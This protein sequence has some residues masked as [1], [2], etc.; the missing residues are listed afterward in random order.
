[1]SYPSPFHKIIAH[2]KGLFEG[3]NFLVSTDTINWIHS[4]ILTITEHGQLYSSDEN[5]NHYL[6]LQSLQSCYVQ[7]FPTLV[8]NTAA[9]TNS[10][11]NI[12]NSNS[13]R[14]KLPTTRR[15]VSGSSD[16]SSN[17]SSN[18]S[19]DP[20]V[21][22]IRTYEN[23][24]LY[25]KI[26]SKSNFGNL[27]SCLI[28]WQ[29]LKPQGLVKKW[30][31]ENK[32]D[33]STTNSKNPHE[34]LVCRFKIYAPIPAKSKNLNFVY[35]LKAPIYQPLNMNE[36]N[37]NNDDSLNNGINESWFYVMGVLKSNGLLN[38]IT[39]NDGT[40]I[41]S[42]DIKSILSSEIRQM[43]HSIFDNSNVLFIGQLKELRNHNN[44]ISS[45]TPFL[46]RDGKL[47]ANNSRILIEFPLHI[48]LEDWFVG[49]NYFSK[50]EYIGCYSPKSKLITPSRELPPPLANYSR[51][52]FRVSKKI[53]IDII[54]AK[55]DSLP[56]NSKSSKIYAE[57][58]MW[59]LP[60][61]RTAIV[62]HS[63]NPFWKEEF[64]TD[65]PIST[66]MIH[67]V[68]KR[69]SFNDST[70]SAGDKVIG[71]VYVTPDILTKQSSNGSTTIMSASTNGANT[72]SASGPGHT[73]NNSISTNSNTINNNINN[74]ITS[75][76]TTS[77]S[78]NNN[79]I[80]RLT[81]YDTTNVPIGKLLISVKL[82]EHHILP[83]QHFRSFE[84]M[85]VHS[86]MKDLITF[87]NNNITPGAFDETAIMLLDIFQSLGVE[88]RWFKS[89][90]EYELTGVDVIT[91]KNFAKRN[92]EAITPSPS[93]VPSTVNAANTTSA[94]GNSS[95]SNNVFNTLFRGSSVFSKSLEKYNL[96]IGQEYLEKVFG[97][98]ILKI[99][100]EKRNC[101]VDPRYVRLQEKALRKGKSI[102]VLDN[103]DNNDS[104]DSL[105][106]DSEDE[107]DREQHEAVVKKMIEI[108]YENLLG[109]A[110][111][112]WKQIYTTSND[113]PDQIK[114]QLKN[115]RI[116][117]EL[118]C[119]PDD[120]VT[121][122]NCLSAF[123]FLRFFCPAILNPKLFY[124][125]KNHQSGLSQRTLTL[126]AKILLNL[127]NRQEFS[128]HKEPH[129][130]RMNEF[131]AKHQPEIYDYFD[132][133]TGRK[134]DFNEKV[135][136][137]SHDVNRFDLGIK[138]DTNSAE[139]P[140]TPYL[141]DKYLR[142]TQLITL[143]DYNRLKPSNPG[144]STPNGSPR[145][146]I[147]NNTSSNNIAGSSSGPDTISIS[148][149]PRESSSA[150][151]IESLTINE[152]K[153]VYQI[154]SLEF[155]KSEFLDLAGDNETEGFI[156]S[157]CRSNENIFSFINSNIGLKDLQKHCTKLMGKIDSLQVFLE[158]FEFPTN[159]LPNELLD[160]DDVDI[161]GKT[162]GILLL[163]EEE[164]DGQTLSN[165]M[166]AIDMLWDSFTYYI[167]S[168]CY[169]DMSTNSLAYVDRDSHVPNNYKKLI[170]QNPLSTL[171]LRF[172]DTK[173]SNH[174][175]NGNGH[176]GLGGYNESYTSSSSSLNGASVLTTGGPT[177]R[178]ASM[179]QSLSNSSISNVLKAPTK[180]P[181][182]KWLS[183]S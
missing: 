41:Y 172:S 120:K 169:L 10:T 87:I 99:V 2:K 32:V 180:N 125:T 40:L 53:T 29:S 168:K 56:T 14:L 150:N 9:L 130:G 181:F 171:K 85:L 75:T 155:E 156:K 1:M 86:P 92:S 82:K 77:I 116:K 58:R 44:Q 31:C 26:A 98:F 102:D 7:I 25:L 16:S 21:I 70:Y 178:S 166:Q 176:K 78:N 42:I 141:I 118:V 137:L 157:L 167:L 18:E 6:L 43:H 161:S 152:E 147:T 158:N 179:S 128:P 107:E 136:D 111:E 19:S 36:T 34:L 45:S 146:N 49:L 13:R 67:I 27:I 63:A 51:E 46:V 162:R 79:E 183:K 37:N 3:R 30:Y 100:D 90:M 69:C 173:S 33:I 11:S 165:G 160:E 163:D 22:F 97:K 35:G 149:I 126:L 113:L 101:E 119:D 83:P 84:N 94:A 48:D 5:D 109:Y 52:H 159:Y 15:S 127:A 104:D 154:G 122:L 62:N 144:G 23:D 114:T 59:G 170:D 135:L 38:F 12:T 17:N 61:S 121:S 145:A 64:S 20:P 93:I 4:H 88:E 124:L 28:V 55:F 132:K 110:E 131:L 96:R 138:N 117:V 71:T 66:Q 39:E 54:E 106:E 174:N 151:L 182:K 95:S 153:N 57:V 60:W 47:I 8:T 74:N 108:N 143:L 91:R 24:K 80:V 140:T 115:F 72:I 123:I 177:S 81:I 76:N 129:L 68:I 175:G 133:I 50:R 142:L 73:F 65:L 105:D 148:T 112:L 103:E 89:L 164:D 139:L 134:N